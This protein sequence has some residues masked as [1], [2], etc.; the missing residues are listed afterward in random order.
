[1]VRIKNKADIAIASSGPITVG[2]LGLI[3]KIFSNKKLVFE[4][5]DLWPEAPIE[6]GVIKNTFNKAAIF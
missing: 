6:L 5:R 2:I 4:A 3:S 1:M